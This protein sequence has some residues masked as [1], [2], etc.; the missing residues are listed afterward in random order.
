MSIANLLNQTCT[1]YPKSGYDKFGHDVSGQ[2]VN[3]YCRF[4]N[5]TKTRI[6]PNQQI[7]NLVGVVYL[8]GS[9]SINTED[10]IVFGGSSYKVFS[11]DGNV[12]RIG[13]QRMIKCEVTV[14][15]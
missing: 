9:V 4:Q 7:V 13:V 1:V 10:R 2:P 5:K 12:D 11:V 3:V 14:W 8:D 15:Q 6:L